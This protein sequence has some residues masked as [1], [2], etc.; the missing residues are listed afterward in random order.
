MPDILPTWNQY[1]RDKYGKAPSASQR[2]Q[3]VAFDTCRDLAQPII[4][5]RNEEQE[6]AA[7]LLEISARENRDQQAVVGRLR[8]KMGLMRAVIQDEIDGCEDCQ[9]TGRAVALDGLTDDY[10]GMI[11]GVTKGLDSQLTLLNK[12]VEQLNTLLASK[13]VRMERKFVAMEMALAQLQGQQSALSSLAQLS[14][15]M[16]STS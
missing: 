6:Y 3:E 11:T 13:R 9:G 8:K 12:R 2:P 4:D 1:F 16:S 5:K 10:D 14:S 7:N 15:S